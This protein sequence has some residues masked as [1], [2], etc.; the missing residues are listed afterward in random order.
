MSKH[1]HHQSK[2][3]QIFN[4]AHGATPFHYEDRPYQVSGSMQFE[5]IQTK[6]AVEDSSIQLRAYQ[7][8]L[9]K[10]GS[11]LDNWLEAERSLRKGG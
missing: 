4:K 3:E 1:T 7:I 8:H 9:E 11:D 2:E 6:A 5:G 10:G